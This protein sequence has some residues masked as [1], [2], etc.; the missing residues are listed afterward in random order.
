MTSSGRRI[1]CCKRVQIPV[2][3]STV[4]IYDKDCYFL[5]PL[6]LKGVNSIFVNLRILFTDSCTVLVN[7]FVA[8]F[9]WTAKA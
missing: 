4:Q 1:L 2:R 9:F 5:Q 8:N 7:I 6:A 3:M